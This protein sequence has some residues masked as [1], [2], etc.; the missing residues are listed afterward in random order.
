MTKTSFFACLLSTLSLLPACSSSSDSSASNPNDAS[1]SAEDGATSSD[2]SVAAD[3]S[4]TLVGPAG[5]F[6]PPTGKSANPPPNSAGE[7]RLVTA[8]STD[9]VHF[10]TSGKVFTDQANVPDM[11][12]TSNGSIFLYYTGQGID[13]DPN[14]ETVPVATSTDNGATWTFNYL[15]YKNWPTPRPPSDPDVVLRPDG[16]FR[17]FFVNSL[18]ASTVG[19][20]YADSPDG[21]TFTY[22]GHALGGGT[23]INDSTTMYFNG[24][25]HMFVLNEKTGEQYHATSADGTTFAFA[26][27]K[28]VTLPT[29]NYYLVNPL[30]DGSNLRMFG[31]TLGN[32]SSFTSTDATNWTY[33][34]IVLDGNDTNTLTSGYIQDLAVEKL[35]NGTYLMVY[36]V[37]YPK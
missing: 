12:V 15:V 2:A 26:T 16:T 4:T 21:F 25:W 20:D 34:G 28:V 7:R 19:I 17:M 31:F 9:G 5:T 11:V 10:T 6:T 3:G 32:I 8:T 13:A 30:I 22:V 36:V 1:A 27:D 33:G 29:K 35:A 37:G 23:S 18:D 24:A 14:K